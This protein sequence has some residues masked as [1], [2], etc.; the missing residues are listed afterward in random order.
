M[1]GL[2][3]RK[4]AKPFSSVNLLYHHNKVCDSMRVQNGHPWSF[5]SPFYYLSLFLS[6]LRVHLYMIHSNRLAGDHTQIIVRYIFRHKYLSVQYLFSPSDWLLSPNCSEL[7]N[8]AIHLTFT[9]FP[10]LWY[11]CDPNLCIF[12]LPVHKFLYFCMDNGKSRVR[13]RLCI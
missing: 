2:H 9:L 6:L 1:G 8:C 12:I 3:H 11:T 5:V 10:L 7:L 4:K 13:E